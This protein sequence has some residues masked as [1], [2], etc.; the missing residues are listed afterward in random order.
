MA[1]RFR[2]SLPV[3]DA[4]R[5]QS[6]RL[7]S[8]LD[9]CVRFNQPPGSSLQSAVSKNCK[10]NRFSEASTGA[11]PAV[12]T[13][14]NLNVTRDATNGA[15]VDP[16]ASRNGGSYQLETLSRMQTDLRLN[17]L[18]TKISASSRTRPSPR[19]SRSN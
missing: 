2:A 1:G 18:L 3:L 14:F 12:N 19:K 6:R 10:V 16:N 15:F 7:D 5:I 9:N 8:W 17:P 11:N 4:D 13:L